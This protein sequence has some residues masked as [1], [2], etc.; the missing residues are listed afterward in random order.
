M[1]FTNGKVNGIFMKPI[2]KINYRGDKEW[3]IDGKR[4]REDGPAYEGSDGTKEWYINGLC[5]REDGPAIEYKDRAVYWFI[6]GKLHREDGPAVEYP[7]GSKYWYY[8]GK[9]LSCKDNQEFLRMIKLMV[10]L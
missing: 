9:H 8:Q 2:C 3:Y 4:H 6:N 7:N 10:F 1:G 5:H